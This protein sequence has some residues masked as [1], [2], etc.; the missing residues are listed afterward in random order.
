MVKEKKPQAVL[1]NVGMFNRVACEPSSWAGLGTVALGLKVFFPAYAGILD[2]V[3]MLGGT[4]GVCM[5]EGRY[6]KD[7]QPPTDK[8]G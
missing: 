7:I 8:A 6:C 5:R 4:M 3:A 2:G 1:P